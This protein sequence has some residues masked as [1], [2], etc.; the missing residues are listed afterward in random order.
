MSFRPLVSGVEMWH[1]VR[2]HPDAAVLRLAVR[3]GGVIRSA[4][5]FECGLTRGQVDQRVK[6]GRWRPVGRFGY[7][8]MEMEGVTNLVRAAVASL[9]GAVVSHDAA[10]E[11][12]GFANMR[13]GVASV[14]VHSR[15]THEFPDVTVHRCHD[16]CDDHVVSV[17]G[18]RV[19]SIPRTIV[20]LSAHVTARRLEAVFA[21]LVVERRVATDD[22]LAV[23][24]RVA[25]RGKP[26]IKKIRAILEERD[27]GPRDGTPLERTGAQVLRSRGVPEPTFEFPLP[28]DQSRRFDAA[29]PRKKLA[30][31]WD[32]RRWHERTEAFERD[33]QRD[34]EAM[35]HGWRVLRFT[36]L[37]VT[38]HPDAVADTVR[39]LLSSSLP[40]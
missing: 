4:Q 1:R 29:F 15:T 20:D 25:R 11:L 26:G 14:S 23:V 17:V 3:Q 21:S 34:R 9:P 30:I 33:R 16:M 19:T 6:D 12:H 39:R 32:S 35:L 10:A 37:D 8:I 38:Q 22:V 28:W 40:A 24:D 36:W 5:A 2:M 18:L 7:R 31:E 27:V 13:R